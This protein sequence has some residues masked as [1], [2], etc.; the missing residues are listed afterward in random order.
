MSRRRLGLAA[1]LLGCAA[2]LPSHAAQVKAGGALD[3]T[4]SGSLRAGVVTGKNDIL[5]GD[6]DNGY[7]FFTDHR[8]IIE[9]TGK[10]PT[11]GVNYGGFV[12]LRLNNGNGSNDDV[13]SDVVDRGYLFVGHDDWGTLQFGQQQSV[14]NTDYTYAIGA[15]SV[16]AGTGGIDGD[17]PGQIVP[18]LLSTTGQS[19]TVSYFS[20]KM[21]DN[22]LT[23]GVSFTPN[24][25]ANGLIAS[26]TT[27]N[28]GDYTEVVEGGIRYDDTFGPVGF[29]ASI[30]GSTGKEQVTDDRTSGISGGVL[31][32]FHWVSLAGSYGHIDQESDDIDFWNV[33]IGTEYGPLLVSANYAA[34]DTGNG[35]PTALV[36]SG[37]FGF[38]P[39][40][41]LRAEVEYVDP[42]V[43]DTYWVTLT[44]LRLDF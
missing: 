5:S 15:Y 1:A 31:L 32:D 3:I 19:T 12:R 27:D 16:A 2:S 30:L 43:S 38:M 25:A 37:T 17:Q 6:A 22:R 28:L 35:D 7:G 24:S 4:I 41:T 36:F 18:Y 39:G 9:A 20:P 11:Y 26:N 23:A 14:T 34:A 42:D 21:L 8:L 10:D 13:D 33:G 44:E 29:A 40:A